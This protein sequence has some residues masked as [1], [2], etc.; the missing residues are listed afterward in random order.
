ML[1]KW[2]AK[3]QP[4]APAQWTKAY[5]AAEFHVIHPKNY[6]DFID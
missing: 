3:K 1:V 4:K 2:S 5:P 6:L